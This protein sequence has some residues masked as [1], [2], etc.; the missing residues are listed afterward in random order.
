MDNLLFLSISGC[1]NSCI[2][3]PPFSGDLGIKR[4]IVLV[5][6]FHAVISPR[7]YDP[8]NNMT[9]KCSAICTCDRAPAPGPPCDLG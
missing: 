9:Y 2:G 3:V 5:L 4:K 8:F 1:V 7:C 6:T